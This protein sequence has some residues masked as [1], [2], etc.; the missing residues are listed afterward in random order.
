LLERI[1]LDYSNQSIEHYDNIKR[2]ED[3]WERNDWD[4][5]DND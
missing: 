5:F 2:R 4:N 3:E 1:V